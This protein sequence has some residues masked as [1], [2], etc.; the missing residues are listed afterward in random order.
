VKSVVFCLRF[1][2]CA[3][4]LSAGPALTQTPSLTLAAKPAPP[5][6]Y[7]YVSQ[8]PV[9][10]GPNQV[11]GF[12]AAASGKLTPILGSPFQADVKYMAVNGKYLFG[13]TTDNLYLNSYTI[14]KNGAMTFAVA[15]DIEK[16]TGGVNNLYGTNYFLSLDHTGAALYDFRTNGSE[17]DYESFAINNATGALSLTPGYVWYPSSGSD[18]MG[19]FTI[20]A[21][22]KYFYNTAVGIDGY[23]IYMMDR[24]S[25]GTLLTPPSGEPNIPLPANITGRLFFPTGISADPANHVAVAF[26]NVQDN[27]YTWPV[28]PDQLGVF[29]ANAQGVLTTTSN[30][31][32]VPKVAVGDTMQ[33]RMS[34]SGKLLAVGGTTGLEIFHFNGG[35]PLTIF[36]TPV[37]NVPILAVR[38][39]NHDHLFALGENGKLYEF[40]V[41]PTSVSPAPGSPYSIPGAQN[42]IVQPL[43]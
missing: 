32:N 34:T 36:S 23:G 30:Y 42:L 7:V 11:Y 25:N 24:S 5:I 28:G 41:T 31:K 17:Q 6:D 21:N 37:K 40:T 39:D 33:I 3:L 20:S 13:S 43:L 4:L 8:T 38:W 15:N 14:G 12:A 29:T 18:G 27:Q 10:P 1:I 35:S 9:N 22:N 19:P 2:L 16:I 26:E